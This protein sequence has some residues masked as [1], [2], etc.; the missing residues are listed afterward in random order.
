M[1]RNC[2]SSCGETAITTFP[3]RLSEATAPPE[4]DA[5]EIP[6]PPTPYPDEPAQGSGT[7]LANIWSRAGLLR[8]D[9]RPNISQEGLAAPGL[10]LDL[11][12]R[13]RSARPRPAPVSG[14]AVYIW[15]CDAA[16]DYSVYGRNDADY[17]RGI[18]ISDSNGRVRFTTIFPGTYRGRAPHIHFEIY[19]SL[20]SVP[21]PSNCML[22]SRLL[23]PDAISHEIYS[24]N[25]VYRASL[26]VFDELVFDRSSPTAAT[27]A[28][29]QQTALVNGSTRVGVRASAAIALPD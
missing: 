17:L 7:S 19:P 2:G 13:L 28:R 29:K 24:S 25:L 20:S 26:K 3:T 18:G 9:I 21:K 23:F 14:A 8:Q 12:L 16:G 4:A 1:F 11:L 6:D 10:K 15:H 5:L 27:Q 22:R